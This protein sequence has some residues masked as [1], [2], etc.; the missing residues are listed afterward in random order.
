MGVTV[1]HLCKYIR[2]ILSDL[3]LWMFLL[4]CRPTLVQ[5]LLNQKNPALM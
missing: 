2:F 5:H 3:R 4:D 1:I